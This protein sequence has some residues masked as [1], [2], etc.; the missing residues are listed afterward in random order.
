MIK[1]TL[2]ITKNSLF[3]LFFL[4]LALPN[5]L[6]GQFIDLQLDV[7]VESTVSTEKSL[8]FGTFTANAGRK[9]IILGDTNM[10]VFSISVLEYQQLLISY[11]K[12]EALVHSNPGI[13]E[14]LPVELLIDYGYSQDDYKNTNQLSESL[15]LIS[16]QENPD[17]GPWNKLYIFI[18]GYMNIG[19]I[20]AGVYKN[21]IILNIEYI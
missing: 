17:P 21:D 13:K 9:N 6:Q 7:K 1:N 4:L 14:T 20:P 19:N 15:N 12:P 3:I 16:V 10:G 2:H 18:Y 11:H 8:N 5:V